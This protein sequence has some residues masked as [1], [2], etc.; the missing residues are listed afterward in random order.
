MQVHQIYTGSDLRNFTYVIHSTD[1]ALVYCIDPY[2]AGQVAEFTTARG[3]KLTHV[4]NTH[5]H[6][7]HINGNPGL[8]ER[9]PD[10]RVCAHEAI[11]AMIP[12]FNQGVAAGDRLP[13][14]D[15]AYLEALD[16]PGHSRAHVCLL[17]RDPA[18]E[19]RS[20]RDPRGAPAAVFTGD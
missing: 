8:L 12:G 10:L 16:T 11:G 19:E 3:L 6:P 15:G 17:L 13:L 7:D 4:I 2:D 18:A 5:E 9:Y 20:A 1:G 14:G